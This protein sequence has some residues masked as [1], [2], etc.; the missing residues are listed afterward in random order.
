MGVAVGEVAGVVTADR[1][2]DDID[3]GVT[4]DDWVN[5]PFI[6]FDDIDVCIVNGWQTLDSRLD[7]ISRDNS[8]DILGNDLTSIQRHFI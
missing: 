4:W 6:E 7:S 5:C 8:V 2:D 1:V 3:A